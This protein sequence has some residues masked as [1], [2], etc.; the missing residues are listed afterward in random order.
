MSVSRIKEIEESMFQ[1]LQKERDQS[2]SLS[3]KVCN[4]LLNIEISSF[5]FLIGCLCNN[6]DIFVIL[7]NSHES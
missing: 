4:I 3:E 5:I 1:A 7:L 6:H 2:K